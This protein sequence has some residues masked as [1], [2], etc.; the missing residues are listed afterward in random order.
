ME[1]RT[2]QSNTPLVRWTIKTIQ[3]LFLKQNQLLR[4]WPHT[5]HKKIRDTQF[6]GPFN[7][8]FGGA[9]DWLIFAKDIEALYA[10]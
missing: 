10:L 9:K 7:I 1:P 3:I 6:E 5:F 8:C 4:F 2:L